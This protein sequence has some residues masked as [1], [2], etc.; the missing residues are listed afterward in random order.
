MK[1]FFI[2][3]DGSTD[4]LLF[5]DDED[6]R[7]AMNIVAIV[8]FL[9]NVNVISFVL[10]SNHVHFVLQCTDEEAIAFINRFKQLLGRYIHQKYESED[11]LRKLGIDIQEVK[12]VDESLH[13][14]IAYVQMNPV[15]ANITHSTVLYPWGTGPTFFNMNK[16]SGKRIGEISRRKQSLML[17]SKAVLP[18]DYLVGNEGYILPE[19]FVP[20][21]FV[22]KL[23]RTPRRYSYYLSNSS[24]A[25]EHMEKDAAPAFRDQVIIA[26]IKDLCQSLYRE[27]NPG[28]LSPKQTKDLI[29]QIKRRFSM[30]VNQISRVTGIAYKEVAEI[31]DSF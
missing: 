5:K 13:R 12:L 23:F 19:S 9:L 25:K 27:E 30:D 8:S 4:R 20:V 18:S 21:Q 10:M 17:R 24:K 29:H 1:F 6:F 22:E 15:A 26:A 14:A 2:S 28:S 3:T 31:L 7:A 11:Y 16:T